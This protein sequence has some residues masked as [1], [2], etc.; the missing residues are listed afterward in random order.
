M[1]DSLTHEPHENP[2]NLG[3][4]GKKKS[5][6]VYAILEKPG[7]RTFWMKVGIAY[8]NQDQ[9]WNVYLDVMPFDG[10][11]QIRDDNLRPRGEKSGT[12]AE[13]TVPSFDLGGIQ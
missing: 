9:S 6:T 10:K 11:L 3:N 4:I 7:K 5:K 2:G 1:D 13:R 8:L 12:P